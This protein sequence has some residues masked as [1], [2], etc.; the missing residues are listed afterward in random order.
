LTIDI[1]SSKRPA[2]LGAKVEPAAPRGGAPPAP[3]W[4]TAALVGSIIAVAAVGMALRSHGPTVAAPPFA[5]SRVLEMYVPM[6]LLQW[7]LAF[8]VCRIGRPR[9]ALSSLIGTGWRTPPRAMGDVALALAMVGA[10]VAVTVM[11]GARDRTVVEA[12]LPT[13]G[14]ERMVWVLVSLSVGFCEELTYRGYLQT[15]LAALTGSTALAIA[16]Q[17]TLFGI[18]HGEQGAAAIVQSALCGVVLGV[19]AWARGSLVPCILFHAA[20]DLLVGLVRA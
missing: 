11:L 6:M 4:H 18:I 10:L 17:A 16:A 9:N 1:P 12:I 15:Q 3:R 13:T 8:Y 7:G 5:R 20:V 2:K 14:G 19:V